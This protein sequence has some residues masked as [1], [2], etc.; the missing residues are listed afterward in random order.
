MMRGLAVVFAIGVVAT[1]AGP[2]SQAQT[3]NPVAVDDREMYAVYE[4]LLPSEWL[5]R[6]AKAKN[7]VVQEETATNWGCMPSGKPME[8]DWKPVL[9]NFR[10][11]NAGSHVLRAGQQ[12]GLPYQVVA[13]ATIAASMN[14][15]ISN[16]VS[17][18]WQGFPQ[19]FP[20]SGGFLQMSVVGFDSSRQRAMVYMAHSCGGLCGGGT[21]HLLER[22][23]IKWRE[24]KVPG[25]V[26]CV[27]AS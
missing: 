15:P 22:D 23:G 26:Q 2:S 3:A 5:V 14:R 21:H 7:L 27:W 6:V 8:T 20:D 4:S 19:R 12:L 24:A 16:G 17:D 10:S 13:G 25:L 1:F 9:G 18:G 11:A